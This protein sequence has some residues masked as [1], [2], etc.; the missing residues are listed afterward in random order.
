MLTLYYRRNVKSCTNKT[1]THDYCLIAGYLLLP[2][3]RH[4][5]KLSLLPLISDLFFCALTPLSIP[6]SA[7]N[8]A[9]L[10]PQR[11]VRLSHRPPTWKGHIKS[12]V[13]RDRPCSLLRS[14]DHPTLINARVRPARHPLARP[15][16][17]SCGNPVVGP[18][19]TLLRLAYPACSL[20]GVPRSLFDIFPIASP[21]VRPCHTVHYHCVV[22]LSSL[23]LCTVS[24]DAN[25]HPTP[26]V[27][28]FLLLPFVVASSSVAG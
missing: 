8:D 19:P 20:P 10:T 4:S 6:A 9:H 1:R 3:R 22:A 25:R 15:R 27:S 12:Q 28:L 17:P 24:H 7:F 26:P 23:Y 18:P 16:S 21:A 13:H 2:N 5:W 11:S 14:T